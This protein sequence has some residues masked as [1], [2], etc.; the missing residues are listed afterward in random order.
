MWVRKRLK[1]SN[2]IKNALEEEQPLIEEDQQLKQTFIGQDTIRLVKQIGAGGFGDVWEGVWK[3]KKVA[4][5]RMLYSEEIPEM[6]E[7]FTHEASLMSTLRH[8]C[9]D[10]V[11]IHCLTAQCCSVLR[12]HN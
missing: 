6:M 1:E 12:S 3:S 10:D 9:S 5:K 7:E 11:M 4:I 2:A 8:V